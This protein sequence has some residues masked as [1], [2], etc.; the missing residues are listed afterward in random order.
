MVHGS[1]GRAMMK[2]IHELFA[3]HFRNEWLDQGNDGAV[4][5]EILKM[6]KC[7]KTCFLI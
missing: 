2:L 3:S 7:L 1:G 5:N 4:L 6:L